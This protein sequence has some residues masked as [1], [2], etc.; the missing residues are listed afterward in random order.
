MIDVHLHLPAGAQKMDGT[1]ACVAKVR[2]RIFPPSIWVS[3]RVNGKVSAIVSLLTG[4]CVPPT[5]AMTGEVRM[6]ETTMCYNHAPRPVGG[7]KEKV[8]GAY[9]AGATKVIVRT[10]RKVAEHDVPKE[11]RAWMQFVFTWEAFDPAFGDRTRAG[12]NNRKLHSRAHAHDATSND[13]LLCSLCV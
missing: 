8:L 4:K 2:A 11:V 6:S 12:Y 5:T 7:V 10:N 1:S 9:R 13:T 3:K